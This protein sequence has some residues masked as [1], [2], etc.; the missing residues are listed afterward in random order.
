MCVHLTPKGRRL[1]DEMIPDVK[2]MVYRS[3]ADLTAA[4]L[5]TFFKVINRIEQNLV[6][7][8]GE[9]GRG[10]SGKAIFPGADGGYD[11]NCHCWRM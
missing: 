6:A 8:G 5:D 4:E 7:E 10:S 11:R 2:A 3:I 9:R 1:R